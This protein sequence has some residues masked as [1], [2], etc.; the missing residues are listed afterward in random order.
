MTLTDSE[1][2][3]SN[4][5]GVR[6]DSTDGDHVI[7]GNLISGHGSDGVRLDNVTGSIDVSNNTVTDNNGAGLYVRGTSIPAGIS[8]NTFSGNQTDDGPVRLQLNASGTVIDADNSLDG[9]VRIDFDFGTLTQDTTWA[10]VWTYRL[11]S[12]VTVAAGTTL[13]LAPGTVI[14]NDPGSNTLRVEGTLNATGTDSAPIHFTESRDDSVG[15]EGGAPGDPVPGAWRGIEVRDGGNAVLHEARIRYAGGS[16]TTSYSVRKTGAGS[17]NLID[18]QVIDSNRHGVRLDST[19]DDH[20]ITGNLISG[21]GSDGIRLEN[22]TGTLTITGN[23]LLGNDGHGIDVVASAPAR[24]TSRNDAS[25]VIHGNRVEANLSAG[26]NIQDS[27]VTIRRNTVTT[28]AG[29]GI[30]LSGETSAPLIAGNLVTGNGGGGIDAENLADP[31]VGGSRANGN[32]IL[33]N[34]DFGLRNQTDTVTIDARC[35]WWGHA[36]GPLDPVNNPDGQGDAVL[37]PVDASFFLGE[38][39]IDTVF[40]DRFEMSTDDAGEFEC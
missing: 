26:I 5:L 33:D 28:N 6:L 29:P 20:V 30:I 16:L 11:V 12:N 36:S 39:A 8:A 14:K 19:D 17:L 21:H 13:T 38:S 3:D 27:S 22:V 23:S 18:S 37:G 1:V 40:R 32:D 24:S 9:P 7:T 10:N 15:L 34:A 35:N 25:I 4:R 2:I 31:L